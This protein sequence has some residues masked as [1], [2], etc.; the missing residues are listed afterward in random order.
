M[1]G[2]SVFAVVR[3]GCT[4]AGGCLVLLRITGGAYVLSNQDPRC[5]QN[6]IYTPIFSHNIRS[7]LQRSLPRN[8]SFSENKVTFMFPKRG[9]SRRF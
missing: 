2:R 1:A 4:F 9:V 3:F 7:Q 6:P 8:R 5:T